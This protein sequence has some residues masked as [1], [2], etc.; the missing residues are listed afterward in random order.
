M[1]PDLK[2]VLTLLHGQRQALENALAG[3]HAAELR[4]ERGLQLAR[5]DRARAEGALGI[6]NDTIAKVTP[7][8]PE[9]TAPAGKGPQSPP[10]G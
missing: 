5:E 8:E 6:I 2:V 3:A 1:T 7:E 10:K 9:P 4:A